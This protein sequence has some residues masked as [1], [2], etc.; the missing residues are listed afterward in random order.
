MAHAPTRSDA[1]CDGGLWVGATCRWTNRGDPAWR[2]GVVLAG[3]KTLAWGHSDH[4]DDALS[5]SGEARRE[6]GRVD[7]TCQQ[8]AIQ[9]PMKASLV[10]RGSSKRCYQ[11]VV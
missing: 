3:R 1:N 10:T 9:T 11:E 5:D 4:S 2:C 6:G 7:G 8:G